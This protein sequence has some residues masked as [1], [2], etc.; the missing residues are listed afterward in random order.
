MKFACFG[1]VE[2]LI[3]LSAG[4]AMPED[5]PLRATLSPTEAPLA[6]QGFGSIV[7]VTDQFAVVGA[8][9]AAT[10]DGVVYVFDLYGANPTVPWL[11]LHDP[12]NSGSYFGSAIAI[13]ESRL[14]VGAPG[15]YASGS[16]AGRAV[17]IY[18]LFSN[19]PDVPEF[20]LSSPSS[21][22]NTQFGASLAI[23]GDYAVVRCAYINQLLVYNLAG[24]NPTSPMLT[25]P[26]PPNARGVALYDNFLAVGAPPTDTSQV[27]RVYLHDLNSPT[28]ANPI[29]QL[30]PPN[31]SASNGFGYSLSFADGLLVVGCYEYR[32]NSH[33]VYVYSTVAGFSSPVLT[34]PTSAPYGAAVAV[35]GCRIVVGSDGYLPAFEDPGR[36]PT[37]IVLV[38]DLDPSMTSFASS[39]IHNPHPEIDATYDNFGRSVG[40]SL[41]QILI[42]SSGE[43]LAASN[44]GA[45]YIYGNDLTARFPTM[46]VRDQDGNL[47]TNNDYLIDIGGVEN[48]TAES[49]TL[50][51]SNSGEEFLSI[52]SINIT[53]TNAADFSASLQPGSLIAPGH[54]ASLT[55]T[56]HPSASGHSHAQLQLA[57]NDTNNNPFTISLAG[58]GA[59]AH[60]Y[61]RLLY[62]G[63]AD[64]AGDSADDADPDGDGENNL[65]EYLAGLNPLDPTSLFSFKV[66]LTSDGSRRPIVQFT[67]VIASRIYALQGTTDLTNPNWQTLTNVSIIDGDN[68]RSIVDNDPAS[69]KFYRIQI[70]ADEA[71]AAKPSRFLHPSRTVSPGPAE[72]RLK[73]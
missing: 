22:G 7:A 48:G 8:P 12:V 31:S 64:N 66:A 46:E 17:Y 56:F 70:S 21:M 53:G 43:D 28:P 14:C 16:S 45:A 41:N 3:F 55:V 58:L 71:D 50:M 62:F 18:D 1:F 37:N 34:L 27:G 60:E 19:T 32:V 54:S 36:P 44:A 51:I 61:W 38:F 2:L 20:T 10:N 68:L 26:A 73:N 47:L 35:R 29:A 67:P 42:G 72:A 57:S 52:D 15:S 69:P 65:L 63:T 25:I 24:A 59:T 23:C 40:V 30:S 6:G 13:S 5:F 9:S 11:T 4:R 33:D 39:Q 49:R